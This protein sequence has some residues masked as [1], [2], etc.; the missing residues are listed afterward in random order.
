MSGDGG[1]VSSVTF[2]GS[3]QTISADTMGNM[4]I[5]AP[6]NQNQQGVRVVRKNT[7]IVTT[8]AGFSRSFRFE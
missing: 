7:G 2:S 6:Y 4:Y 1:P 5:A 3:W 8:I